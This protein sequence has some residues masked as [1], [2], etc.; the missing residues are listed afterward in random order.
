MLELPAS[1]SIWPPPET[2]YCRQMDV[3]LLL[4]AVSPYSL[5]YLRCTL[6]HMVAIYLI[7]AKWSCIV[8]FQ[9]G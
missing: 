5:L 1:L 8:L 9:L 7:F 6:I 2:A 4:P 3:S